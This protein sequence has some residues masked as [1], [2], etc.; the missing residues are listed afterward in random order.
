[1]DRPSATGTILDGTRR[2]PRGHLLQPFVLVFGKPTRERPR[3][4]T[5]RK[6]GSPLLKSLR[7]GF[8]LVEALVVLAISG[9]ALA[10][11]FTIG[12]KAGDTGFSLG[13]RAMDASE[14][15]ISI[16]DVR[17]LIRSVALRPP[18]TFRADGDVPTL[19][20]P[21]RFEAEVVMERAN[22]CGPSGWTGRL[23]LAIAV[24]E[25]RSQLTCEAG[26]RR[27]VLI[28]LDSGQAAFSYS[29]D[30]RSW[31]PTYT[32]APTDGQRATELLSETVWIRFASSGSGDIVESASSGP[33]EA[34]LRFDRDL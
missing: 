17:A 13:R 15:D 5:H 2:R 9:M 20:S 6:L 8:S 30:G 25:E 21:E 12:T 29:R 23:I 19:G 24:D 32:N 1:M 4:L 33:P 3:P 14:T 7:S 22:Q 34:W 31:G 16:S 27:H 18:A 26:G 11:I 10:I 28:E